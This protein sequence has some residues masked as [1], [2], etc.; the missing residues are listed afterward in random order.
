MVVVWKTRLEQVPV[1]FSGGKVSR[2]G[3]SKLSKAE[4]RHLS[5]VASTRAKK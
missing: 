4:T 2:E 5:A 3:I 1:L